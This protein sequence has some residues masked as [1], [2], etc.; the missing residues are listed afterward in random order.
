[1]DIAIFLVFHKSMEK[2]D[3]SMERSGINMYMLRQVREN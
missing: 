1:M 3:L 2:Y